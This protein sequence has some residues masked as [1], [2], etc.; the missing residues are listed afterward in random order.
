MAPGFGPGFQS[1]TRTPVRRRMGWAKLKRVSELDVLECPACRYPH[2]RRTAHRFRACPNG[3]F[4]AGSPTIQRAISTD[5]L[6][7]PSNSKVITAVS[8]IAR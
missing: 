5:S 3:Y 7:S 2:G 8:T 1:E 6:S 4:A